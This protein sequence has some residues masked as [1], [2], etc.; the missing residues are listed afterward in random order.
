MAVSLDDFRS[1]KG[2]FFSLEPLSTDQA[3]SITAIAVSLAG[4]VGGPP[5][6][7]DDRLQLYRLIASTTDLAQMPFVWVLEPR[8]ENITHV[9][10]WRAS[11]VCPFTQTKLPQICWGATATTWARLPADLRRLANMLD[12]ARQLLAYQNM[13]SRAR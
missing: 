4:I 10:I 9:N 6:R 13:K 5:A 3:G 12:Y 2:Q 7:K 8:D 1:A 11:R